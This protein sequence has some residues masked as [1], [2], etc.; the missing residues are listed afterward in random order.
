M[1]TPKAATVTLTAVVARA[2]A[3]AR[4]G[5][6]ESATHLATPTET[7]TTKA[8]AHMTATAATEAAAHVA[9]ATAAVS[10]PTTATATMSTTTTTTTGRQRVSG[11]P[12]SESGSRS[13]NDHDLSHHC[14]TPSDATVSIR[15]KTRV[16]T[17]RLDCAIPIDDCPRRRSAESP[18]RYAIYCRSDP[19]D[20]M[21]K[22]EAA[23][24][25]SRPIKW[26]ADDFFSA[27]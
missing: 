2:I 3:A 26:L 7:A 23:L 13:Q 11:Q 19:R 16:R 18:S 1:L 4:T 22:A 21:H 27:Q 8:A 14:T 24:S 17:V 9:A 5:A 10:S 25:S 12:P 6:A 20:C 15:M